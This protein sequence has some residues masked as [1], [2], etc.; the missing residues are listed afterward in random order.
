MCQGFLK[1]LKTPIIWKTCEHMI[2]NFQGYVVETSSIYCFSSEIK[3]KLLRKRCKSLFFC[4]TLQ[5]KI[6]LKLETKET[7]TVC[8]K[9]YG[10]EEPG[11]FLL[12]KKHQKSYVFQ[13]VLSQF[14]INVGF[15]D[16]CRIL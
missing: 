2:L 5:L 7:Y 8:G 12:L 9:L 1:L 4:R 11:K 10:K 6:D 14:V 15:C 3:L 16:N 13:F